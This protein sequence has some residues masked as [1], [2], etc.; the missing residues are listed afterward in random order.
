MLFFKRESD[1]H[2][3][4]ATEPMEIDSGNIILCVLP[5]NRLKIICKY[6]NKFYN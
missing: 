6:G 3:G 4:A 1:E 5:S 2:V